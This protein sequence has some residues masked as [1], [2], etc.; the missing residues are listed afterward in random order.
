VF[1]AFLAMQGDF[2]TPARVTLFAVFVPDLD[3]V[4]IVYPSGTSLSP[5]K[6]LRVQLENNAWA[7]RVFADSFYAASLL[8]PTARVTWVTAPGHWNSTQWE[9]PW[10]SRSLTQNIPSIVLCPAAVGGGTVRLQLY[11][12]RATT[13]NGATIAWSLTTKQLGD[14]A[15]F[16][17]WERVNVV[18]IGADVLVEVSE[19]EGA[20]FEPVG[21]F[22][23]GA[24]DAPAA[25]NV[26]L[27]RVSTRLQLRLSGD[28][29]A[30]SFRYADVVSLAESE[31]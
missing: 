31:W 18:A 1:S 27:D 10:D 15:Q 26:W 28:D 21:T 19:D 14:G 5:N 22:S 24:V 25:T 11:E 29:P 13:D 16:S 9:R 12:Y 23:F 6:L 20:T 4:W 2:N 3:E 17:R 8:L 7:T 30:F